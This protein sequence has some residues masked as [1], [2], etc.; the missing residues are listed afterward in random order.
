LIQRRF[1]LSSV[2]DQSLLA[3]KRVTGVGG[4][5]FKAKDA[6][7]LMAWYKEH[8]GIKPEQEGSTTSMFQWREEEHPDHLGQTVW[9]IFPHDS[10]YFGP[11]S[12]PFMINFR[13]RD[14]K[15]LLQQLRKEGVR[16]ED[17][18][19]EYD[20]GT[21]GWIMDLE[22]NRIELWEPTRVSPHP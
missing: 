13:V 19:V 7:K 2:S 4:I 5:F 6:E 22:G 9:A 3:T 21:F 15:Q 1:R 12:S 16:V 17:N 8:L 10:K 11:S 18:I 20:F 14:L